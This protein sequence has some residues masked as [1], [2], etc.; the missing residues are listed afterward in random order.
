VRVDEAS[1]SEL[2]RGSC[3]CL[4]H[5]HDGHWEL[6]G[7]RGPF[8]KHHAWLQNH[9]EHA[10]SLA[11]VAWMGGLASPLKIPCKENSQ[12]V[13]TKRTHVEIWPYGQDRLN[14]AHGS[15][16]LICKLFY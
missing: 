1:A 13:W 11:Q 2:E 14:D 6:G 10:V 9:I 16:G 7:T 4:S 8:L 12:G 5:N 15:K 3:G